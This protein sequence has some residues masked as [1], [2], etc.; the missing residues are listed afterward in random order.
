MQGQGEGFE[1]LMGWLGEIFVGSRVSLIFAMG[2][3]VV[4][5]TFVD[6]DDGLGVC[7]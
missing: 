3:M 5:G 4:R 2:E 1:D 7:L 6:D